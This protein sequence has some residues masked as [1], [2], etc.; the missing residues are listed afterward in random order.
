MKKIIKVLRWLSVFLLIILINIIGPNPAFAAS[1]NLEFEHLTIEE[2]L[3]AST[4][5]SIFQDQEGFMWFSTP[6]GLNKYDGYQFKI[7]KND[8]S[9]IQSISDNFVTIFYENG[10]GGNMGWNE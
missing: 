7:Y 5:F 4:V 9:D 1:P 10:G 6:D 8:P 2:G 3:S